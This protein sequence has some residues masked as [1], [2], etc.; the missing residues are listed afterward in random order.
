MKN[1]GDVLVI[2]SSCQLKNHIDPP[3]PKNGS[4]PTNSE[5]I[6]IFC[7]LVNKIHGST[8]ADRKS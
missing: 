6:G 4:A 5:L 7:K 8:F 1:M 2:S 3:K